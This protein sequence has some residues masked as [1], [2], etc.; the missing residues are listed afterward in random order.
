MS[1]ILDTGRVFSRGIDVSKSGILGLGGDIFETATF[2]GLS[3]FNSKKYFI[4]VRKT[5]IVLILIFDRILTISL[6]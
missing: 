5:T 4:L 2:E 3:E 6:G 1:F